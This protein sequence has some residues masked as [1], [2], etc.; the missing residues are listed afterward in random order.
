MLIKK[1]ILNINTHLGHI[2]LSPEVKHTGCNRQSNADVSEE[3]A[4]CFVPTHKKMSGKRRWSIQWKISIFNN[5]VTT[6]LSVDFVRPCFRFQ[7]HAGVGEKV[8]SVSTGCCPVCSPEPITSPPVPR[9]PHPVQWDRSVGERV[10][11]RDQTQ[12]GRM[13]APTNYGAVAEGCAGGSKKAAMFSYS[14]SHADILIISVALHLFQLITEFKSS[15]VI[16]KQYTVSSYVT[17]H[18]KYHLVRTTAPNQKIFSL[19]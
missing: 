18:P 8:A 16:Y 11:A 5:I 14:V 10:P 13:V 4:E 9:H 12:S 19:D 2:Y 15:H 1:L 3:V 7:N 17:T 6:C